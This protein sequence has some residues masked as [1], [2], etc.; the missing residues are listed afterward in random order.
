MKKILAL[1]LALMMALTAVAAIAE[2]AAVSPAEEAMAY[3]DDETVAVSED[4]PAYAEDVVA[5]L[6]VAYL[7]GDTNLVAAVDEDAAAKCAEI[8]GTDELTVEE[9]VSMTVTGAVEEKT[10]NFTFATDYTGKESV[11]LMIGIPAEDGSIEWTLVE[12]VVNEDG[13]VGAILSAELVEKLQGV[14][15]IVLVVSA[16]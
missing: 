16:K 14:E 11:V 9:V 3:T 7:A 8:L 2:E 6:A 4:V 10:V 12:A 5:D 1:V 15:A 13:S